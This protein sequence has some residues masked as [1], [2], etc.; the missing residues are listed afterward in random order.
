M[1]LAPLR[2]LAIVLIASC[3]ACKEQAVCCLSQ[4][5][6][7]FST[8]VTGT[9]PECPEGDLLASEEVDKDDEKASGVLTEDAVCGS[10]C[11]EVGDTRTF[12]SMPECVER[13][14]K[15]LTAESCDG[16]PPEEDPVGGGGSCRCGDAGVTFSIVAGCNGPAF[17]DAE[18]A[19]FCRSHVEFNLE[20]DPA[21]HEFNSGEE[22]GFPDCTVEITCP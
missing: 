12:A 5:G 4:D 11:C 9:D 7:V 8:T 21:E 17:N 16:E 13:N 1:R 10:I 18:T 14:G 3:D 2:V 15:A 6:T 22:F 19:G 20:E